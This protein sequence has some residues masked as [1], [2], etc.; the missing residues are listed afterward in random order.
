LVF[1]HSRGTNSN[2]AAI[3]DIPVSQS[4]SGGH[5][6]G[7]T[8]LDKVLAGLLTEGIQSRKIGGFNGDDLLSKPGRKTN[9]AFR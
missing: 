8:R 9:S 7:E 1:G 2:G 5:F 6:R 4:N 3:H